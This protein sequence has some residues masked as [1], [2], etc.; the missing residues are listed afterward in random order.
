M[1]SETEEQIKDFH[2]LYLALCGDFNRFKKLYPNSSL[3]PSQLKILLGFHAYLKREKKKCLEL[4]KSARQDHSFFEGVRN[5][6]LGLAHNHFGNHKFALE[7]LHRGKE[8]LRDTSSDYFKILNGTTLFLAHVN[9]SEVEPLH[10]LIDEIYESTPPTDYSRLSMVMCRALYLQM[11]GEY[12]KS[13]KIINLEFKKQTERFDTFESSF[14]VIRFVNFFQLK[15]YSRCEE[16]LQAYKK[17]T[18]F[19]CASNYKFMRLLFDHIVEDAPLYVY[20]TDFEDAHE[21]YDQLMVIKSLSEGDMSRAQ[22]FWKILARH[23]FHAYGEEFS[24][25][26]GATL[27]GVALA[28]Q[29]EKNIKQEMD[30]TALASL[31]SVQQKLQYIFEHGPE[32]IKKDQ[33]IQWLWNEEPSEKTRGRLRKV[34]FDYHA[35]YGEQVR[36]YQ[37]TYQKLKK[38][39]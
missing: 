29:L 23:N 20:K 32:T 9:R 38:S 36:S 39:A 30:L 18:G 3:N 22:E 2:E 4:L 17:A 25:Q 12:E 6:L 35:K 26:G 33:L 37:D 15:D 31:R 34:I 16:E 10:A 7:H 8:L 27:F 24:Y 19:S 13:N 28:K 11:T 5:C 14:L 1:A 21:L